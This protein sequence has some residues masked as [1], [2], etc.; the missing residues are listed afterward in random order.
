MDT[1]PNEVFRLITNQLDGQTQLVDLACTSRALY[2]KTIPLV[3]NHITQMPKHYVDTGLLPTHK[4]FTVLHLSSIDKLLEALDDKQV[5]T[6]A[7]SSVRTVEVSFTPWWGNQQFAAAR[8]FLDRSVFPNIEKISIVM[9]VDHTTADPDLSSLL[10]DVVGAMSTYA[11][12]Y[13]VDLLVQIR[14]ADQLKNFIPESY[15]RITFLRVPVSLIW[16][17]EDHVVL[18]EIGPQLTRIRYLEIFASPIAPISDRDLQTSLQIPPSPDYSWLSRLPVTT[19][20]LSDQICLALVNEADD[21]PGTM[22]EFI[23][24]DAQPLGVWLM[25][26]GASSRLHKLRNISISRSGFST[27]RCMSASSVAPGKIFPSVELLHLSHIESDL[28]DEIVSTM[29][30]LKQVKINE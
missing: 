15:E 23:S 24:Q 5:G 17:S 8:A 16:S 4:D 30:N 29:P 18:A 19:L 27:S 21:L 3:W 10:Q 22:Q 25:L 12:K 9:T 13:E 14:T 2:N 26:K 1:L 6:L 11:A 20:K 7:G 28:V